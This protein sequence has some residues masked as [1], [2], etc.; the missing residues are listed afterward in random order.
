MDSGRRVE[1]R[2]NRTEEYDEVPYSAPR[3]SVSTLVRNIVHPIL[4]PKGLP[5]VPIRPGRASLSTVSEE[6]G[7]SV[8]AFI[9]V[10]GLII[11]A[12][13][14]NEPQPRL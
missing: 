14:Y 4:E 12:L 13:A 2:G 5:F 1:G 6:K 11:A 8:F 7:P 9:V 3:K 10:Q